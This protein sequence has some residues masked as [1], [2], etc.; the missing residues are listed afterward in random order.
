MM[1][2]QDSWEVVIQ[3]IAP[4]RC[5]SLA[6]GRHTVNNPSL[7]NSAQLSGLGAGSVVRL[8]AGVWYSEHG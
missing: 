1:M 5:P 2:M 7:G 3:Y 8:I 6:Y 4:M